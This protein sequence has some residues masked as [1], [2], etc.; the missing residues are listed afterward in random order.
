LQQRRVRPWRV[1]HGDGASREAVEI[2]LAAWP[3]E[4]EGGQG[5]KRGRWAREWGGGLGGLGQPQAQGRRSGRVDWAGKEKKKEMHSKLISRFRKMNKE[6]W[7]TEIF[8][9]II[10]IPIKL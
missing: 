7:V 1:R 5:E 4:D 6:I 8:G 9:K 3:E 10:N 2:C